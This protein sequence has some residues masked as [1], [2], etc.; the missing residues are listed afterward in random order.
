[1]S[2]S[3]VAV[4]FVGALMLVTAS[5]S[6]TASTSPGETQ[7]GAASGLERPPQSGAARP[8][9]RSTVGGCPEKMVAYGAGRGRRGRRIVLRQDGVGYGRESP[10]RDLRDRCR[11]RG[12]RERMAR[13]PGDF[14][15]QSVHGERV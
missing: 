7:A 14:E 5:C 11:D 3:R 12:A 13:Q 8:V 9:Q 1:M 6:K 4:M 15:S 10:G 2:L